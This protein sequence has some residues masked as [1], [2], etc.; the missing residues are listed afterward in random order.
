MDRLTKAK[1]D[2]NLDALLNYA[3]ASDGEVYLSYADGSDHIQLVEYLTTLATK[4][5]CDLNSL[6]IM[7]GACLECDCYVAILSV[8]ATQAAELRARLMKIEDILG[9]TY[10]LDHL[11]DLVEAEK[12]GRVFAPP[13]K[14]GDPIWF[15]I[16]DSEVCDE[17]YYVETITEVGTRG[18]WVSYVLDKPDNMDSFIP[19]DEIGKTA[20]LTYED[21]KAA[22]KGAID[23][24]Q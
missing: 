3:Y 12:A 5:G 19:W 20:F 17:E 18:L 21:A 15:I 9:D 10:D 4:C 23:G 24:H 6:D 1:P 2:S 11:R 22:L 7:G 13:C 14:P 16:D 8:V